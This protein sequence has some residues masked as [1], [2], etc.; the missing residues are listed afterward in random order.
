MPYA[1]SDYVL[2]PLY[3][4]GLAVSRDAS[5]AAVAVTRGWAGT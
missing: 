4:L 3:G 2:F 1:F 5:R